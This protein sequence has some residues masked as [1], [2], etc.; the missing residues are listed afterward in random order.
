MTR[1]RDRSA[2]TPRAGTV[3]GVRKALRD[4]GTTA[5]RRLPGRNV[6]A[7]AA[8]LA[9]GLLL[10]AVFP[11]A[12][13]AAA[14]ADAESLGLRERL[15]AFVRGRAEAPPAHIE[16]PELHDFAVEGVA[17]ERVEVAISASPSARMSGSVPITVVLSAGGREIRR[18]TVSVRVERS[19]A[20]A[21]AARDLPRGTRLREGDVR[22]ERVRAGARPP[23]LVADASALLGR[24]TVRSVRSGE[25]L[26]KEHV[27]PVPDVTRGHI[28]RI[29]LERG[30]LRIEALGEAR[31]DG[32][33]GDEV[34]VL[35][36]DSRRVLSGRVGEDGA[37]HVAF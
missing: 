6:R 8:A 21:V 24:R 35:N 15:E 11:G 32:R 37:V 13:R 1:I 27:E 19:F 20:S 23:G 7:G 36:V 16:V 14:G 9:S 34:R 5:R 2:R 10:L 29:V 30:P 28:V 31:E 3:A 17:A 25:R 33:A 4:G 22:I 18:G 26:R 12:P